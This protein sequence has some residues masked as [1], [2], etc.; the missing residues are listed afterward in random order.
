MDLLF[1]GGRWFRLILKDFI[2]GLLN[3][4]IRDFD[5]KINLMVF[6]GEKRLRIANNAGRGD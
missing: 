6:T 1:S 4:F 5:K 2:L 3:F